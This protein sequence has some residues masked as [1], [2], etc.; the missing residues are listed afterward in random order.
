MTDE[1]SSGGEV[2]ADAI[3]DLNSFSGAL[4]HADEVWISWR[5]RRRLKS[6]TFLRTSVRTE[7]SAAV[8][9]RPPGC[10]R[11]AGILGLACGFKPL[12]SA[13]VHRSSRGS[14]G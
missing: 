3:Y 2:Y 13:A 8:Y 14:F 12:G 5:T 1:V 7:P 6:M 11:R 10:G 4:N 9:R